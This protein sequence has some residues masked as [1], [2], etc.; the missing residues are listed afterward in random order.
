MAQH[1]NRID[2]VNPVALQ[3]FARQIEPSAAGILV[4]I[5]QNIRQLQCPPERVGDA[6]RRFAGVAKNMDR[7]MTNRARH[8]GAIK[9]ERG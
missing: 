1:R 5:A 2:V 9:I 4:E 6:V 8:P 7:K 3:D